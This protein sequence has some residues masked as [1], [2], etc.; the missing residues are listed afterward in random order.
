MI[1]PRVSATTA[2]LL[3]KNLG[4]L[5]VY[6]RFTE[7]MHFLPNSSNIETFEGGSARIVLQ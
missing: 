2:E 4:R 3:N 1:V 6:T 5:C 7:M